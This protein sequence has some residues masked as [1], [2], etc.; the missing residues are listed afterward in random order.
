MLQSGKVSLL[1]VEDDAN[2]R[3]LMDV[4]AQRSGVFEPIAVY[5]DG[6]AA[7][8]ALQAMPNADLPAIIVSDLSMPNMTGLELVRAIKSDPRLHR[9]PVAIITSSDVPND[10]ELAFAA[11]VCAFLAKPYGVEALMRALISIRESCLE[12]AAAEKAV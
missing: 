5:E 8:H 9:I 12:S 11:G 2:I 3:F 10:R 4:A 7:L 1:I 6:L